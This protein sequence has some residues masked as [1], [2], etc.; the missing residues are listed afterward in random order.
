MKKRLIGGL[1]ALAIVAAAQAGTVRIPNATYG[2]FVTTL[3]GRQ[4]SVAGPDSSGVGPIGGAIPPAGGTF[5]AQSYSSVGP[6]EP[7]LIVSLPGTSAIATSSASASITATPSPLS[8][9]ASTTID[10][11]VIASQSVVMMDGGSYI[12]DGGGTFSVDVT[13]DEPTS[14]TLTGTLALDSEDP[15]AYVQFVGQPVFITPGGN[16]P[17]SVSGVLAPGTYTLRGFT[18]SRAPE[19]G[20][21]GGDSSDGSSIQL[22]LTLAGRLGNSCDSIDFNTDGA[23]FDPQDIDAFLSVFSEGPCIPGTATCNDIDFNNDG[24]LFDPCD[25]D[26]FLLVFSEGPCT[27]CGE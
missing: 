23:S 8:A 3:V 6:V 15:L 5:G 25:I 10:I 22:T 12:S 18:S 21:N 27:A 4:G 16:G 17:L 26:A 1:A 14:Y 24:S 20:V 9:P 13:V 2:T 11:S 7:G 19:F